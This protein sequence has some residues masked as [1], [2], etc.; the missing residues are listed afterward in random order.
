MILKVLVGGRQTKMPFATQT[1]T[2]RLLPTSALVA[3]NTIHDLLCQLGMKPHIYLPMYGSWK[4]QV[5]MHYEVKWSIKA[6]GHAFST[7]GRAC[8]R[9]AHNPNS[10]PKHNVEQKIWI[11][12]NLQML[13]EAP[14]CIVS[15]EQ[16]WYSVKMMI[17]D[18]CIFG[19]VIWYAQLALKTLNGIWV[20]M[21]QFVINITRVYIIPGYN[22]L[23][24]WFETGPCEGAASLKHPLWRVPNARIRRLIIRGIL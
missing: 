7:G 10:R 3:I 8:D 4:I 19:F 6:R 12:R 14:P 2:I 17:S 18:R 24:Y 22:K 9:K 23:T 13:K 15:Y 16:P 20:A 21:T 5:S 11:A 1:N